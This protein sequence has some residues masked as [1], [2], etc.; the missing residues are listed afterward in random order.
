MAK[1]IKYA[2]DARKEIFTG[3]QMVADAVKVTM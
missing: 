2:D 1:Q 3:M